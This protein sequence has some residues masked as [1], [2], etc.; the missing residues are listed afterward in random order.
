MREPRLLRAARHLRL[1]VGVLSIV[2]TLASCTRPEGDNAFISE[3]EEGAG[4]ALRY[5][6]RFEGPLDAELREALEAASSAVQRMDRPAPDELALR[7]RAER[8]LPALTAVLRSLGYYKGTARLRLETAE[9]PSPAPASDLEEFA[10][11]AA[12]TPPIRVV[13]EIEPGPRYRLGERRFEVAGDPQGFVPP[14]PA[15]LGLERDAPATAASVLDAEARLVRVA[16]ERGHAFA[17]A[18]PREVIVDHDREVMDVTLRIEP[19][20]VVRYGAIQF[21]GAEGVSE[22]YLRRLVP[23]REGSR[24]DPRD[25]ERGRDALVRSGLFSVVRTRLPDA[26]EPENRISPV[27]ELVQRKHRSIGGGIGYFTDEGPNLRA[28]WEHRNAFGAG[29][30]LRADLV[31]SPIRQSAQANLRKPEVGARGQ[32]LLAS[33]IAQSESLEAF[34]SRS[35]KLAA[36]VERKLAPGLEGAAGLAWRFA[37]IEDRTG[38]KRF[39]LFS[40]PARL[41]WDGS[42]NLFDPSRG[43][44]VA[45][46]LAPNFD[47]LGSGGRFLKSRLVASAYYP[48]WKRPRLVLAARAASG[49]I[50]GAAREAIPADERW[51]AGGGGSIRGV[52]FQRAGPLDRRGDPVGGRS[53]VEFSAEIRLALSDTI[54]FAAF[55]DAGNAYVDPIPEP[56]S[57]LRW[58]TGLGLRYATPVGPL[59]LDVAVPI[60]RKPA[61]DDLFQLYISLGQAF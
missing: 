53:F 25:L 33:V 27:F 26:P 15:Q 48:V 47:T 16:Q 8:D 11:T 60:D 40:V 23:A 58:G 18:G 17:R 50:V 61:V 44:R 29:E 32:S 2:S 37:D 38:N 21:E 57:G 24:F 7:R 45:F 10:A 52:P 55:V 35:L 34:E 56:E 9:A 13:F 19:G 54:G 14:R 31:L 1:I 3:E 51:Y 20:P 41:A 6:V 12:S 59:R 5:E 30:R 49:T 36:G 22:R 4:P 28:F 43:A 46:E 42:D 39:G